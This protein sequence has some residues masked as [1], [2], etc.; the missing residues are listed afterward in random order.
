MRANKFIFLMM[1]IWIMIS[2]CTKDNLPNPLSPTTPNS[3]V[4]SVIVNPTTISIA[5]GYTFQF[6]ATVNGYN[7]PPQSVNW[8]VSGGTN[9]TNINS[10]GLL[11][12]DDNEIA[13]TLSVKATSATDPTKSE[14]ATV[15]VTTTPPTVTSVVVNPATA[16]VIKGQTKLFTAE[17]IGSNNPLQSV[18]WTVT[19]STT[20]TTGT[21]INS[22]GFLT[23][24]INDMAQTLIVTATSIADPTKSGTATVTVTDGQPTVTSVVV[25]PATVSVTKGYTYQFEVEVN[26][27]NNPP[28][29]VNWTVTGGNITAGT[30]INSSGLLTV[31]SGETAQSLTV[32]ATST[33]D[34]TKNGT[35]TVTVTEVPPTV[36][37]VTVTPNIANVYKGQTQLFSAT[38]IGTN[39][40]LQTVNWTITGNVTATT[41]NSNG[42]LTVGI[43]ETVTTLTVV[44]TSVFDPSKSGAATVTIENP[45][46]IVTSIDISPATA[47]IIKGQTQQFEATV[48]GENDPPQTVSWEVSGNISSA[49]YISSSGLL[50]VA[51]N[52]TAPTL[53]VTATSSFDPLHSGT[54]T[55]TVTDPPPTVT[56][57]SVTP[58]TANVVKGETQ[59]FSAEVIGTNNPPQGVS[60]TIS[61]NATNSTINANGLFT[62]GENETAI[63]LTVIATSSFDPSQHGT[64]T[65]MVFDSPPIITDVVVNP[66]TVNVIKGH[67]Q[68]FNVQVNGTNAPSQ[69]VSWSVTGSTTGTTDTNISD[70]GLLSVAY[71]EL[72]ETLTVTATSVADPTKSDAATVTVLNPP[73]IVLSVMV[74]PLTA[75]VVKGQ[76]QQFYAIV[77]GDNNP[78][79]AVNW[80][81]SGSSGAGTSISL[82]GLL[83]V[84]INESAETLTVTAISTFDPSQSGTANVTV[85]NPPPTVTEV[86]VSPATLTL[87]PGGTQQFSATVTGNDNPPQNVTWSVSGGVIGT[88][89]TSNGFL[90]V[91]PNQIPTTLTVR[92]TSVYDNS[93]SGTASV[94]VE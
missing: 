93:K 24:A 37:S 13:T 28:Q 50:L 60:W 89:I 77:N 32:I 11:S 35:A 9:S 25:S 15:T 45:P 61:D 33:L 66:P 88:T 14:T 49:T 91:S 67:T 43:N 71:F 86:I 22:S 39:N 59:L 90:T 30:I 84:S 41:I 56:S 42:L 36:T 81:V 40:P 64:A 82:D 75:T 6:N 5:K 68:Q 57:V 38:V 31:G 4:T 94:V 53:L 34:S 58:N 20:G 79:Q 3:R 70:S 7:N 8:T 74:N 85:T 54:A 27:E 29:T 44:A 47:N 73:P 18:N 10:T 26:G 17:V 65:V 2:A 83:T 76:T 55:V 12:I 48:I 52:E 46:P 16:T 80:V 51:I 87:S 63:S 19:G 69:E 1:I 23:I 21:N 92:A 78:P 72:A 62:V